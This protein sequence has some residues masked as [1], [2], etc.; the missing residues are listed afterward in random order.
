LDD[1]SVLPHV[2]YGWRDLAE[3][4]KLVPS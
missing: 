3:L 2:G 1:G 4:Y